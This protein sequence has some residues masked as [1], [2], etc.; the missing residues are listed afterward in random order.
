[1]EGFCDRWRDTPYLAEAEPKQVNFFQ[2]NRNGLCK[3][4]AA[5]NTKTKQPMILRKIASFAACAAAALSLAAADSP[6]LNPHLAPLQ[7]LLGKTWKG[8][9]KNSKPD[10]PV[11]DVARWERALNGQAVRQVHS[12]NGGVYGGETMFIWD[13]KKQAVAYYYF[14]T[15]GFMT[16]GTFLVKDGHF[17]TSEQ[18][19]GDADGVTE[20]R[21]TSEIQPDGKF[22]VK[23]EYLKNGQWVPGHEVTY[24][25]NPNSQVIFK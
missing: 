15:E 19:T 21:G 16:T 13:E 11:I 1:M 3:I 12:I 9:F 7:P 17:V 14:T 24:E 22:H 5:M 8:T 2:Y 6:S 20:V 18:V 4:K 23:A 10:Q 25:E